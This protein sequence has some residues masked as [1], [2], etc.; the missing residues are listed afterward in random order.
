MQRQK[1]K[2][3][4][5]QNIEILSSIIMKIHDTNNYS[6]LSKSVP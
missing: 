6:Q 3:E 5:N 4:K 2:D 1:L